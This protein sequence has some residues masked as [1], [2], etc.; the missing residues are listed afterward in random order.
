M[1]TDLQNGFE[2]FVSH[3]PYTNDNVCCEHVSVNL[4]LILSMILLLTILALTLC[5]YLSFL[6]KILAIRLKSF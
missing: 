4:A 5:M 2:H 1:C 3:N 6:D